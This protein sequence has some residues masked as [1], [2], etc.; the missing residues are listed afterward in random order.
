MACGTA[1]SSRRL[2]ETPSLEYYGSTGPVRIHQLLLG[3]DIKISGRVL[4][5]AGV[6]I[7]ATSSGSRLIYK[8]RFEISFG[9]KN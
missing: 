4:W 8:S 7:G 1:G 2:A 6:G 3:A 9:G 5:S